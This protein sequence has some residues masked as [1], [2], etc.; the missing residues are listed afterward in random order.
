ML[1]TGSGETAV[2]SSEASDSKISESLL[3]SVTL[4]PIGIILGAEEG[5]ASGAEEGPA[6]GAEEGPAVGEVELGTALGRMSL[7]LTA[8]DLVFSGVAGADLF[9]VVAELLLALGAVLVGG[10][11]GAE[12]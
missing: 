2:T 6:C 5:P 11:I 7:G 12:F 1:A 9:L 3:L 4:G 10:A 8:L